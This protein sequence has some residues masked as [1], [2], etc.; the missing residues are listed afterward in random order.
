M[1]IYSNHFWR[2][3]M[4]V[5]NDKVSDLSKMVDEAI[6]DYERR[7][8]RMSSLIIC[9]PGD[10]EKF[11]S[12]VDKSA[13][14]GRITVELDYAV[15]VDVDSQFYNIYTQPKFDVAAQVISGARQVWHMHGINGGN[16]VTRQP[17]PF[18]LAFVG[19]LWSDGST[20]G[21]APTQLTAPNVPVASNQAP[22]VRS[23][24]SLFKAN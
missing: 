1:A 9:G 7:N 14:L 6:K 20:H 23:W 11:L 18:W 2:N 3:H 13:N 4:W 17:G 24:A 15:G 22:A 16:S 10:S 5:V 8:V 19:P 21:P 12:A